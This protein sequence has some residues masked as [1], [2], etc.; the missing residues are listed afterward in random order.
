MFSVVFG[1]FVD[2]EGSLAMQPCETLSQ[3]QLYLFFLA[4]DLSPLQVVVVGGTGFA[5]NLR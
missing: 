1:R 2:V 4:N 3:S 5:S